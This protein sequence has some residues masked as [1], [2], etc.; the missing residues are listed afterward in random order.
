MTI[1]TQHY[2]ELG[3]VQKPTLL[4]L[5]GLGMGYRMWEPQLKPLSEHFHVLAPDMPGFAGSRGCGPFTMKGAAVALLDLVREKSRAPVHVCGLSLGAMVA[6][7]IYLQGAKQVASLLLSGGQVHPNPVVMGLQRLMMSAVPE[8][9]FVVS[10]PKSFVPA[11]YPALIEAAQ[12]EV[13]LLGKQGFLAVLKEVGGI[14]FRSYLAQIVI[15]TLVLCGSKDMFNKKAAQELAANIPHA[16]L[17]LIEEAGHVWN[18][19]MPELFTQ[20]VIEF[21]QKVEASYVSKEA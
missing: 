8:S 5:H 15:P 14:Q 20:T 12:E 3:D 9:K 1:K 19:Q 13:R 4:L 6:L 7:E 10:L 18:L 16:E 17:R 21:V 2:V 11:H